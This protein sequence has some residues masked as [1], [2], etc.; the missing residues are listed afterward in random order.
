MFQNRDYKKMTGVSNFNNSIKDIKEMITYFRNKNNKS[1]KKYKQHKML[2]KKIKSFDRIVIFA[3]TSSSITLSGTENGLIAIP[4]ST[5]TACGLSIG[6]KVI[7]GIVM[8]K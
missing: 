2:A 5:A 1:K 4:L 7:Y 6:N 8:Q 3:T